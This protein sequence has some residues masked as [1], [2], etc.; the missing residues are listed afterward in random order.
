MIK[1]NLTE[2]D[3]NIIKFLFGKNSFQNKLN[4]TEFRYI[5]NSDNS[6]R[7]L[8]PSD[9]KFPF[10]LNF[11]STSSARAKLLS[12]LIKVCFF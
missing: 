3:I 5:S 1:S 10:F 7:W 11:Y 6:V 12:L 9:L 2:E 4:T 8:F